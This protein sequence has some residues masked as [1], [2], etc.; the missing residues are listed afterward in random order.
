MKSLNLEALAFC[1][2]WIIVVLAGWILAG[3][4]TG[5]ALTIGLFVLIMGSSTIIF[6][7]SGDIL[8]ERRMR[9]GILIAGAL[10]LLSFA[11]LAS[12]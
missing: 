8:L 9:W 6:A 3:W 10:L 5:L 1:L 7:T 11:D 4:T 2:T 12:P